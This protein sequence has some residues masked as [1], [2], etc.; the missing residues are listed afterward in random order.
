MLAKV[1]SQSVSDIEFKVPYAVQE[2]VRRTHLVRTH[3]R[4]VLFSEVCVF[5]VDSYGW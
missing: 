3:L 1:S 5:C 4:T 2:R